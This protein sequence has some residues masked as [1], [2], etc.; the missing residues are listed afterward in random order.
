MLY[1]TQIM[2]TSKRF[3]IEKAVDLVIEAGFPAIDMT[4]L[5]VNS[6]AYGEGNLE[7]AKRLRKKADDAGVVFNQAHAPFG[8][9]AENYV[10]NLIPKFDTMFDFIEILGVKNVVVHP[11]HEG[12]Y[13][14]NEERL[15]NENIEFFKSLAPKAKSH[16]MK[17]AIE[18]M[19]QR[20][21]ITKRICDDMFADPAE[22]I[23][24]YDTLGDSDA[25]TICLDLG[26]VA[27]CGREPELSIRKIGKKLGCLHV[28]DVDYVNDL[29]TLPGVGKINWDNVCHALA[30]VGYDGELT[31]EADNFLVGFATELWP[32]ALKF[33]ADVSRNLADRIERYKAEK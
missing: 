1:S 24:F 28:Q 2:H 11:I 19:W 17:I 29:H 12:R 26:H 10:N 23:R 25:F 22:H 7:L 32:T 4:M 16:G 3:G 13:Q 27:T 8:G 9:G 33:M 5:D 6:E 20:H 14:G 31:L 18:N 30:D 15:F 21:P